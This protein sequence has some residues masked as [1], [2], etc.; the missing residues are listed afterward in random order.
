M[1]RWEPDARGRMQRAALELFAER[2][3]EQTSAGDIAERA[4]VTERT[5][6]RHFPDKREVLFAGTPMDEVMH[7]GVL[8]APEHAT[9]HEAALAGMRAGAALLEERRDYAALRARVV[10]ATPPL[11][12][13]ELFK[14]AAMTA[15]TYRAL[16]TRGVSEP[17]ADLAAHSAVT[18]FRVGFMRW[19]DARNDAAQQSFADIIT[20]TAAELRALM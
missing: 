14:S 9:P 4:G 19:V 3:Y 18:V 5:F 17:V 16:R 15:A 11:R 20:A 7:D 13:R 2:G 8:A 6:F 12:E 1:G 10:E